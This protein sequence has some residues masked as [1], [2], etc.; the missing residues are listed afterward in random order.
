MERAVCLL[1]DVDA[2][3]DLDAQTRVR[4]LSPFFEADERVVV[5]PLAVESAPRHL[6][7]Y[8][9]VGGPRRSVGALEQLGERLA[10]TVN[11]PDVNMARLGEDGRLYW[12]AHDREREAPLAPVRF[13]AV[14]QLVRDGA[15]RQYVTAEPSP[16]LQATLDE[17]MDALFPVE[18]MN[19]AAL[20]E[21][22]HR[23]LLGR[24]A[25]A[26]RRANEY[27]GVR[28]AFYE[29]GDAR[30]VEWRA[31]LFA[32]YAYV[33]FTARR[34]PEADDFEWEACA[35]LYETLHTRS[36][37]VCGFA[38][39]QLRQPLYLVQRRQ[40]PDA[41]VAVLYADGSLQSAGASAERSVVESNAL[42]ETLSEVLCP[43]QFK[44]SE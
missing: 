9:V 4:R 36:D 41:A 35:A 16:F 12:L 15:P 6:D 38:E 26:D 30:Q 27:G 40:E 8:F 11:T 43:A 2:T 7:A 22:M 19:A 29:R 3:L 13:V 20:S 28:V 24:L 14:R 39:A 10:L 1:V 25:Q 31:T 33:L 18:M 42:N 44:P 17:W 34:V 37:S 5:H 23:H 21:E 32:K